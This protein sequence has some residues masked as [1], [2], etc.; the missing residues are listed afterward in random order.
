[1]IR[2]IPSYQASPRLLSAITLLMVLGTLVGILL[3]AD[4]WGFVRRGTVM[5]RSIV[6][7]PETGQ[8]VLVRFNE[9]GSEAGELVIPENYRT[10]I[11]ELSIVAA[12][13]YRLARTQLE[14]YLAQHG[15][16]LGEEVELLGR[17]GYEGRT[18]LA[19]D[20]TTVI[21]APSLADAVNSVLVRGQAQRYSTDPNRLVLLR[22]SY[23]LTQPI[24]VAD[25]SVS[26]VV[27]PAG[28][29]IAQADTTIGYR[30]G[31][32]GRGTQPVDHGLGIVHDYD[33]YGPL[34]GVKVDVFTGSL[35]YTDEA[36]RYA[37]SY[38]IPCGGIGINTTAYAELRYRRFYPGGVSSSPYWYKSIG[39]SDYC[40][41]PFIMAP[42]SRQ[43][44][45]AMATSTSM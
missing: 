30:V 11:D 29:I 15:Y 19:A 8:P 5:A 7:D 36:G 27:D 45:V 12:S 34:A 13:N 17:N 2:T 22:F 35:T 4:G 16:E 37:L 23:D 32:F 43:Q 26:L 20:N 31:F 6:L 24:T 38:R 42:Q 10:R 40:D 28:Y 21:T 18:F 1:M 3:P 33:V 41:N 44:L 25:T 39:M 14:G 9:D